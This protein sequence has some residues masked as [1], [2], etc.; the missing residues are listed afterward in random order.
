M[1]FGSRAIDTILH[2][3]QSEIET[4]VRVS[5]PE[6][7]HNAS[8]LSFFLATTSILSLSR[9]LPVLQSLAPPPPF[10]ESVWF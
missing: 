10:S 2:F 8:R 9:L 6:Q 4:N 3:I 5:G 7:S 1:L